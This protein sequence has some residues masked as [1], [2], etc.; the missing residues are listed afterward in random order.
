MS[1][2]VEPIARVFMVPFRLKLPV[3]SIPP[4]VSL[5]APLWLIVM[6][7]VFAEPEVVDRDTRRIQC[8]SRTV[9]YKL[10]RGGDAD[11]RVRAIYLVG[12]WLD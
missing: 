11:A 12:V 6:L 9:V 7:I 5:P 3:Y 1:V 4:E 10:D 8:L 2:V